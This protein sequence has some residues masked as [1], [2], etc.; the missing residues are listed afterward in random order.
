MRESEARALLTD[1]DHEYVD[2]PGAPALQILAAQAALVRA[3]EKFGVRR[4]VSFHHRVEQA[5]EFA[6]TLPGTALR[7]A[8]GLPAP[9]ARAVHGEMPHS[10]RERVLD[11]LRTPPA[12]GW[13]VLANARLLGEGV[14]VPALDAVLFAHPK[15]SAV[16]IV[17]AVGR[18]L[19]RHPDTPGPSTIIVPLVVPEEDGEIG[20]LEPGDYATLWQV[21]RA[22][23]AHDEPLGIALDTQR[24][25][26]SVSNPRLPQKITVELPPGTSH[27]VLAQI[28]LML[29]RQTTS[30]WWEGCAAAERF[31]TAHGHL[32]IP[33]RYQAPDGFRLGQWLVKARQF[34]RRGQLAA[35]RVAA[36]ERLGIVWD[37]SDA[38]W[39]ALYQRAADWYA[40]HGEL[41]VPVSRDKQLANW[42]VHQRQ[43]RRDGKL[44]EH[45]IDLLD[46]IGMIWEHRAAAFQRNLDAL[47]AFK[48]EHGHT[49]VPQSHVQDGIRLGAFVSQMRAKYS[50]GVLPADKV[51]AL[52]EAGM[53]W[54]AK[55]TAHQI[56]QLN[57]ASSWRWQHGNLQ[58]PAG[59]VHN[60]VR[61]GEWL[62]RQR[63]A[64][65]DGRLD[66]E[67]ARALNAIDPG[68]TRPP[69]R[70]PSEPSQKAQAQQAERAEA[71]WQK[72]L[73]AA[74]AFHREHGHL[75]VPV[76]HVRDGIRLDAWLYRQRKAH[77]EGT[78]SAQ[79]VR[80]LDDLGIRW[81]TSARRGEHPHVPAPAS[82]PAPPAPAAAQPSPP[83]P[84]TLRAPGP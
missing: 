20:D 43:Y 29:V 3:A 64:Y 59:A 82:P 33:L 25:H 30:A 24:A 61:L 83:P 75:R 23:R 73:A 31:R 1:K 84:A 2:R 45:R 41:D 71:A 72:G 48:A 28:E 67:I 27:D 76:P 8:P 47:A 60:G 12:G 26:T 49:R 51:Q 56:E 40:R 65:Q 17:Q 38:R 44:A 16:D 39:M 34:H 50:T 78:L 57:A 63:K 36:L 11:H 18:A 69:N 52:E 21:V 62:A 54:R 14:D 32:D 66:D 5:A 53:I 42:L 55:L 13:T 68:W 9:L 74:A 19:R 35:D 6:R 80:A 79:R 10:V 15:T 81:T 70:M 7:L 58:V 22:L 46:K 4:A 77:K 37:P